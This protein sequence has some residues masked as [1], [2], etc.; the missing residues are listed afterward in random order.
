MK[1][2]T[3]EIGVFGGSGFYSL[4]EDF[5]EIKVETPYGSPS[6]ML[7][8][9]T[10]AGKKV[11]FLPRHGKN[12]QLPPHMIN[13]RANIYAF[14]QLGCNRIIA[15]SC[16]GSLQKDIKPGDFVIPDQFIDRTKNRID[17]FYDGPYATHVSSAEVFCPSLRNYAEKV[18]SSLGITMHNG[19]TCVTI[20]GPRFS[21][22]A[23]SKWF[24]REGWHIVS[25]T[26]YPEC[27]L[28]FEKELCY[29]NI[30]LVTDY[31]AGIVAED[32][33]EPVSADEVVRVLKSNTER[34]KKLIFE[35]IKNMP[36]ARDCE[37]MNAL[38]YARM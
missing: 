2:V 29:V 23:E 13:Y 27:I 19:G 32:G 22:K 33:T 30:S 21:S 3:A 11:A 25:M 34:V 14:K 26:Q 15:S 6:D 16:V 5:E 36:D 37:C 31:D 1:N 18:G 10:L 38:K 20:Q 9:G 7:A 17:T 24:T 12:H 35:M 28:A 8:V 4:M